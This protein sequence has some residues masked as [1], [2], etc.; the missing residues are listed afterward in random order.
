MSTILPRLVLAI[1]LTLL[2][3]SRVSAQTV[4]PSNAT[5]NDSVQ[6]V[7]ATFLNQ[8]S[9]QPR[10]LPLTTGAGLSGSLAQLEVRH[11]PH[12][13]SQPANSSYSKSIL[14]GRWS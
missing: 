10:I 4:A 2:T 3:V 1:C 9:I 5:T 12:R 13:S 6:F 14:K 11:P 7:M 8:M